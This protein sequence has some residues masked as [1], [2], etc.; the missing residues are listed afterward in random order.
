MEYGTEELKDKSIKIPNPIYNQLSYQIKQK[1]EKKARLEAK[2]YQKIDPENTPAIENLQKVI[3]ME[4]TAIEQINAFMEEIDR[5]VAERKT[6][7][8][9]ISEEQLPPEKQYNML[10]QES[11]KLKNIILMLACRSES[12]LYSLLPECYANANKDGRQLLKE[13]FTADANFIPD[14]QKQTF[15]IRL[16]ALSTPRANKTAKKL[17]DILNQT[18]S[19]FPSTNLKLIYDSVAF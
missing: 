9:R 7:P 2:I 14:Y 8:A 10:K 5:L 19:C 18:Q 13:I 15:T 11:K 3:T 4:E 6:V 16:H 12:A 1:R 17:C